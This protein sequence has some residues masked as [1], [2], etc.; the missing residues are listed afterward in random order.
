MLIFY[1]T[2]FENNNY[3]NQIVTQI[4]FEN[5][6]KENDSNDNLINDIHDIRLFLKDQYII[7]TELADPHA[8][9]ILK[10]TNYNDIQTKVS[11][12]SNG[13]IITSY[14]DTDIDINKIQKYHAEIEK[15]I[16]K[17]T[18]TQYWNILLI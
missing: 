8:R 18:F 15:N 3:E 14:I 6:L 17:C 11:S 10:F 9:N 7:L 13:F 4:K 1:K 2:F 16:S 5:L 12:L